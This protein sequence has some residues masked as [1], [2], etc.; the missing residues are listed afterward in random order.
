MKTLNQ[1]ILDQQDKIIGLQQGILRQILNDLENLENPSQEEKQLGEKIR[2]ALE[3]T[4]I[5]NLLE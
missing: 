3:K 4:K 1:A 5:G 2:K